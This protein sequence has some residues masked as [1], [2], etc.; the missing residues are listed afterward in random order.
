MNKKLYAILILLTLAAHS[1]FAAVPSA[2]AKREK[3]MDPKMAMMMEKCMAYATANENHKVLNVF[4]GQ[5]EHTA[6]MWMDP[7]QP[8]MESNGTNTNE[9]LYNGKFLKQTAKGQVMGMPF[10]GMGITGYDN[11]LKKYVSFWLDTMGT[12]FMMA[13]GTYDATTKT[14]KETGAMPN[15]MTGETAQSFRAEWKLIDNDHYTYDVF[16]KSADGKESP[17]LS[18]SYKRVK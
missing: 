3:A 6:K 2:D 15:A 4:V 1:A 12:G 9:W 8:P 5:W 7:A 11:I 14:I 16:I 13:S 17:M 10:E 18:L